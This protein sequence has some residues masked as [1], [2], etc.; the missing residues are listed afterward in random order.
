ML[1]K[2]YIYK[3]IEHLFNMNKQKALSTIIS[4]II[5]ISVSVILATL[6]LSWGQNF[7]QKSTE[8][9][10]PI[11]NDSDNYLFGN[12]KL[13]NT[14]LSFKN[15]S[16]NNKSVTIVAYKI[17]S[18][19]EDSNF[20][21]FIYLDSNILLEIGATVVISLVK[22]PP[23]Q[24]FNIELLT[25]DNKII[26]IKDIINNEITNTIVE[27]PVLSSAKEIIDF[28]ILGIT[29]QINND[30]NI[31]SLTLPYET[32]ITSLYPTITISEKA[33]IFPESQKEQDFTTPIEYTVT[34]EDNSQ[35]I[36]TINIE[37][38]EVPE[39]IIE[40]PVNGEVWYLEH[41]S[42]INNSV[43][44]LSDNYTLMR[45]LDFNDNKSYFNIENKESYIKD[46]WTPIGN[47]TPFTGSFN[48]N[49]KKIKN[50]FI[51]KLDSNFGLFSNTSSSSSIQKLG[52]E[53]INISGDSNIGG[54]VGNNEGVIEESYVTGLI[55]GS[56]NVG[57]VVGVNRGI[58]KNSYSFADIISVNTGGG[59]LGFS[60]SN[61]NFNYLTPDITTGI[62]FGTDFTA[63]AYS[64]TYGN[65]KWVVVGTYGKASYS[66]DGINWT[67]LV[68]GTNTG[69]KFDATPAYS[70]SY[71]ADKF[72]V[73]GNSGKASY[74][75]DGINWTSLPAGADTGIRFGTTVAYSIS[76]GLDKFVVVGYD[77]KAS[78][79]SDGISWTS[80]PAGTTTG[81]RFGTT[82]ANSVAYGEGKWVVVGYDGKASYSSD[83]ISWTSLPAGTD[84]GIK[85]N[86][87]LA[88]SVAYGKDK[89]VVVGSNGK[90]SYSLDGINWTSLPAGTDTGI[91]FGTIAAARYVA[92]Y[93][94]LWFVVGDDGK[95]S[96]SYDG[97]TW[98]SISAKPESGI[99]FDTTYAQ[100]VTGK[101]NF[102]LIVGNDGKA[103]YFNISTRVENCFSAGSV[104]GN[105]FI[106]G[107]VGNISG[108]DSVIN[109]YW[110]I[111]T[112]SRLTSLKGEGKTTTE[113]NIQNTFLD[114]DFYEIWGIDAGQSYPF[115]INNP[116]D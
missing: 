19:S 70:V 83:G 95:S 35:R 76:R 78:Y 68:P 7:T 59:L 92:Y 5:L 88:R 22:L 69:I 1:L 29:G 17:L 50:L 100:F 25:S 56:L 114:W 61:T 103:S 26:L 101:N 46:G 102:W 96:Y 37:V 6:I 13:Q 98:T 108:F 8:E 45:N 82:H 20:N 79:S 81:I 41:L 97:I 2:K 89:W 80:L 24:K 74:S 28:E 18:A 33:T 52:L 86:T 60:Q 71:G 113:M 47:I 62:K 93:G 64:A 75:S 91:K 65:D 23:E 39:G 12:Q 104:S 9:I 27:L 84:T 72:V 106:G 54:I 15:I 42:Y 21:N 110:D 32:E 94:G 51:N 10:R 48:G 90:A 55:S 44:T 67:S 58:I 40:T 116:N 4:V 87:T 11:L 115:F 66:S 63:H 111:N 73:V 57:G 105:E 31:V 38:S 34:A 107:L 49:N 112:S 53:D 16:P 109:S 99:R 77:G 43:S 14:I 3:T 36:Y 30:L 85:F